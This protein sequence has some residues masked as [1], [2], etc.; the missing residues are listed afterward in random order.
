MNAIGLDIGTTTI[1]AAAA[2]IHT[3]KLLE[4]VTVPNSCE[5]KG[6]SF[7]RCQ[8]P[9][10]ILEICLSALDKL[11]EKYSPV[12]S[13]GIT[14]Q[15][16]GVIYLDLLGNPL[17]PL[18]T[19]QDAS[20]DEE[21]ENGKTYAE[22]LSS[23]TGY[24]M[25]SGFGCSTYFVHSQKDCVPEGTAKICTVHDY[26]A[27]KLTGRNSPVMH[28]SDAASFGLFD[29]DKLCF[30]LKAAEAAGLDSSVLP[31]IA[32]DAQILG[33]YR[34]IPVCIAI[35]DNQA[36]FIG[37]VRDTDS[38]VLVNIGTGSQMSFMTENTAYVPSTELRPC[39]E[40]AFLRVG[41][42]LCGGRA[43]AALE[44]FIRQTANLAGG[45]VENAYSFID[46]YLSL[47]Q[48]PENP[49][50]VST[51]FVGTR[52]T[53]TLRGHVKNIGLDNFTPGHLIYGVLTAISSELYD[54]YSPC[55]DKAHSCVVGSGNGLR[56][57]VALQKIISEMFGMPLLI[58][59]HKEEA[60]YGAMLYSLAACGIYSDLKAAQ[61]LIKYLD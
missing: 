29:T 54:M 52:E 13:I 61:A 31:E 32:A 9:Q 40:K 28:T 46:E 38:S 17:S 8:N 48:A 12:C 4:S 19:W 41:S 30:D 22:K 45:S 51:A 43:F 27:M 36:S 15:M 42:A 23:I 26:V 20:A 49:L 10:K 21:C 58:P 34:K 2:D 59:A 18:Y 7:E 24:K 25:A 56:K 55:P 39:H 3:G 50:D 53:P 47:N 35:G 37:S 5:I 44:S 6:E 14:G 16:H 11:I 57:N 33:K 60:A 1:C